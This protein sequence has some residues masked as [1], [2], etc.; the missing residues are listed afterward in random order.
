MIVVYSWNPTERCIQAQD[1][2]P[3]AGGARRSLGPPRKLG[4]TVPFGHE[5]ESIGP[6]IPRNDYE[7]K[8]KSY[9]CKL[10]G[11]RAGRHYT[12]HRRGWQPTKSWY[13]QC[14]ARLTGPLFDRHTPTLGR[15]AQ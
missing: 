7:T 2:I 14:P 12:S 10:C 6:V 8:H 13:T 15:T 3:L 11:A 4:Q 1:A 5:W 9:R